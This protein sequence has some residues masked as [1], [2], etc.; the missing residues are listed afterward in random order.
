MNIREVSRAKL[1]GVATFIVAISV[2]APAQAKTNNA[3]AQAEAAVRGLQSEAALGA[4]ADPLAPLAESSVAA[5]DSTSDA[6]GQVVRWVSRTHDNQGHP[7]VIVDKVRAQVLAFDSDGQP[8]GA[9]AALLGI[10]RGDDS[11]PGVGDR[12]LRKIPVADRTTPAGRFVAKYGPAGGGHSRVLW[13]DY[14][15]AVSLHPVVAANAKEHRSQRI[16]SATPDD[17][18]ITFGCINVPAS[19][20]TKVVKPLFGG[21]DGG[22]VYILPETKTLVEVF[23]GMTFQQQAAL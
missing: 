1:A 9:S 2:V 14:G 10:T 6:A 7:F 23:P 19:F 13:V 4:P 21:K 20:Y 17:N 16:K 12:E 8:A 15:T 5:A 22:I 3:L 18:R 11:A